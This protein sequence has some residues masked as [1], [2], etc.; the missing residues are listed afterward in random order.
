MTTSTNWRR[1]WIRSAVVVEYVYDPVGNMNQINRSTVS[2]GALSIF[3]ITP[4]TVPAGST[5]TIQ[6]QGFSTTLTAN[7]VTIGG[8][9]AT[10]LKATVMA[11]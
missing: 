10:V 3:N 4:L 2:A 11:P 5:I 7:I 8:V 9:A 1:S 6:G